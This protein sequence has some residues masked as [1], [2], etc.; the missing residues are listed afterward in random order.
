[1]RQFTRWN[2]VGAQR[3]APRRVL[4]SYP[5][6]GWL[7]PDAAG[8]FDHE[9]ELTALLVRGDGVALGDGREAALGA[10][11]EVVDVHELRSLLDTSHD[12]VGVLHVVELRGDKAED[13]GLALRNEAQ[14]LKAAGA[15]A[16]VLEE[17]D[18][19]VELGEHPL[20]DG[21]A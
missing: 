8:D 21:V 9:L 14:R 5:E 4:R 11:R 16:V 1:M 7:A 18:V 13:D 20:G 2:V 6:P 3:A 17:Q 12:I 10:Q 15:L 19:V